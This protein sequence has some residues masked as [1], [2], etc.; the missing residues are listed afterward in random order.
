MY[1]RIYI[2]STSSGSSE[3]LQQYK[4]QGLVTENYK[5]ISKRK[6]YS[7][8]KLTSN[9]ISEVHPLDARLPK[10]NLRNAI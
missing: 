10:E 6:V 8:K 7:T 9:S 4:E 5:I 3:S 2:L 1:F